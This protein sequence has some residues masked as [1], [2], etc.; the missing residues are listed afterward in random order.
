MEQLVER[1]NKSVVK[2][3]LVIIGFVL[4][5]NF[6]ISF[7]DKYTERFPY[8]TSLT[9]ILLVTICCSHILI[10]Y[11]S[12]YLYILEEKQLIF[13]RVIGKRKLEMLRVDISS[14]IYIGPYDREI[15]DGKYP[16]KFI[17]NDNGE[18]IYIGRFKDN[19]SIIKFLFS[20]NEGF[21]K[22][23]KRV[24]KT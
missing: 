4:F 18:Q 13:Y 7:T 20:P 1:E 6:I 11:F 22:E 8:I 23:L 17:F 5:I 3:F 21:L 14:L 15:E 19:N 10:K 2:I 9:T 24:S 16:Y 12:K